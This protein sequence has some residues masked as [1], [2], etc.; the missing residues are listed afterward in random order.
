MKR[1]LLILLCVPL[2]GFGQL[3]DYYKSKSHPKAKGLNFQIKTP[4]GFEQKEADRPNIVQKW[5]K[6]TATFM[7]MVKNLDQE[8]KN[9]PKKDWIDYLKYGSGVTDLASEVPNT[10]NLKYYVLDN[11]PGV[12]Y[13]LWMDM[14]RNDRS[15]RLHM[16][17]ATVFLEE[18]MFLFQLTGTKEELREYSK[19]FYLMGNSVI[20]PDQYGN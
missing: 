16:T 20:F 10:S 5:T 3:E 9:I 2:I 15:F 18:H 8:M 19:L 12:Y 4:S 17:Q 14:E 6:G 1:L 13:E 11:Y 7:V